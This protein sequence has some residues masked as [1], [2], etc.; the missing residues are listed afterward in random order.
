MVILRGRP[1]F[2]RCK[3]TPYHG[4]G[5]A[6]VRAGRDPRAADPVR[7]GILT[8][9]AAQPFRPTSV[10]ARPELAGWLRAPSPPIRKHPRED[11]P[12]MSLLR[13]PPHAPLVPLVGQA[14]PGGRTASPPVL[15]RASA[16]PPGDGWRRTPSGGTQ[17]WG[18]CGDTSPRMPSA[19][20]VPGRC[21]RASDL[22]RRLFSW[23]VKGRFLV[24]HVKL[25]FENGLFQSGLLQEFESKCR[26]TVCAAIPR[27]PQRC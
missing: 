2:G 10:Y 23:E 26:K 21:G 16:R 11:G 13:S 20:S 5:T 24:F 4:S 1:P 17:G 12:S 3:P 18:D 8:N 9:S 7:W 15:G 27:W 19:G 6:S 25:F 22:Q 14:I